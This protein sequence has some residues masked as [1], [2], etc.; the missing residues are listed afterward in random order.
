MLHVEGGAERQRDADLLIASNEAA[1]KA[2]VD[3]FQA[4]STRQASRR[5][6]AV[7]KRQ[8]GRRSRTYAQGGHWNRIKTF[9][10][11]RER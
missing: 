8:A 9:A 7:D 3:L 10:A 6:C 5:C 1:K 4:N 11:F 2:L